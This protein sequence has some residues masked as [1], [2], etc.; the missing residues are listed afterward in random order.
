MNYP[1]LTIEYDFGPYYGG[2]SVTFASSQVQPVFE[3]CRLR[4]LK[5]FRLPENYVLKHCD[6]VV[7]WRDVRK[8]LRSE[9]CKRGRKVLGIIP[10]CKRKQEIS[11]WSK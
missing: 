8:L 9:V 7:V 6:Y 5:K 1:Q 2:Y 4:Y 3:A 10:S 11:T